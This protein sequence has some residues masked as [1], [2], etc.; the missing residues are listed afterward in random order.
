[1]K[2]LLLTALFLALFPLAP[3]ASAWDVLVVQRYRA[4]PYAEVVRGFESVAPGKTSELVLEETSANDLMREIRRRRP[5]L[6]LAIGADAL[7]RVRR[8][9]NIPI[10]YCMVLNPDSLLDGAKNITGISMFV[11]PERQ[12]SIMRRAL[13]TL[14][15]VGTIYNPA[16][17]GSFMGK[18]RSAARKMGL[19]LIAVKVEEPKN[20]PQALDD[21]P[22]TLDAYW[23]PPDSTFT[24]PEAIEALIL[25]S[26]RTRIPVITFSEKYL[27]MGA[28]I[29]LEL[30][31]VALGRQ[32][33]EIAKK[34]FNGTPPGEIS[35]TF[36]DHATATA[37][38]SVAE[39]LGISLNATA[40]NVVP[41][42]G[43]QQ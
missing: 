42:V 43:Q 10:I 13:P 24:G 11:N 17:M 30:D 14:K 3:E 33:G 9:H 8:I 18:A 41:Q 34:I 25:F 37:N 5:D 27:R 6:I 38:P 2:I 23:M 4:K 22:R 15:T 35:S 39:K 40:L 26:I 29:S 7:A 36:A 1:M 20:F 28:L 19:R 31:T 16:N 21:L 32:A 12:F